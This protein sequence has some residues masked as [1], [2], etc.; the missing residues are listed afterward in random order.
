MRRNRPLDETVTIFNN[1]T[2]F[3]NLFRYNQFNEDIEY[4]RRPV[5]SNHT[6]GDTINDEDLTQIRYYLSN[7]HQ[8][9]PNKQIIGEACLI[10]A[11]NNQY[12]PVKKFI[13]AQPW[14]GVPRLD[15]WLID[16]TACEDNAYTR[17]AGA[18][19]L[20]AAVNRIYNPGCKFD[21]MLI[22]EGAQGIGKSTMVEELAGSWYLDTNFETR[23]KDL[24][25]SMRGAFLI[26]ISEL[27]GMNKKDVDWLKSFL[28]K[29]ID[30]VRLPYAARCKDFKRKS[31]FIGTYN[32]SGNNT[33]LRDD[34][35]NRRFWPI[36]C[37][38]INLEF[39]RQYK[40]QLWAEAFRR[41]ESNE[42]YYIDDP[43]AIEIMKALHE[44]RELEGPTYYTIREYLRRRNRPQVTMDELLKECLGLTI[45]GQDQRSLQSAWTIIGINMRR[46]GWIKGTNDKRHIYFN[47]N[48]K[49]TIP[50]DCGWKNTP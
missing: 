17:Q 24:I 1:D 20:I 5:W 15:T 11:K 45:S 34:T 38:T 16:S 25:D 2:H 22:L 36:E 23:D 9:E 32:P 49:E 4:C 39:I 29:K 48:Y 10:V 8:L 13:E 44:D 42:R 37:R 40:H 7:V 33:Y 27:S 47:P 28:T 14:D 50:H 41:F 35:G 21:H 46:L 3:Q 26:E 31:V 12:H 30:R 18:K 43:K 6:E 19:F